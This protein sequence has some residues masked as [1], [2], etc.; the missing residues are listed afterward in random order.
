MGRRH[1][2]W[3]QPAPADFRQ[4]CDSVDRAA[5]RRIEALREL[6]ACELN[7]AQFSRL[8]RSFENARADG[9]ASS[10]ENFTLGLVSN[11][12]TDL[13]TPV[14]RGTGLRYGFALRVAN[15]PFGITWQAATSPEYGVL[16][17]DPDA[18]LLALDFRAYFK[19]YSLPDADAHGAVESAIAQLQ[20][21]IDAFQ[22]ACRAA[23]LVQSIPAPPEGLF[24]SLDRCQ[25][26]TP[27]WLA[28][29]FN[30]QL[31]AKVMRPG[32]SLVDVE[33]L[34]AQVGLAT[35][36]DRS[37]Y[38]TARL[39]FAAELIPLYADHVLRV[40]GAIRGRGRKVLVLDLDNTLWGGV[41]GDDG[42]EGI[43]LG[44][45]D[46]LG[47]ASQDLQ[48]AALALKERGV[49]LAVCSKN[50]EAVALN[51]IQSHVEMILRE[52]DFS[53]FQIN[54]ADKATNLEILAER[55][56][57]GLD[58]FVFLD[59]NPFEREQ[60][61]RSLPEVLVPELPSDPAT[62]ARVLMTGGFFE[63]ITFAAEDRERVSQYAAN[64]RRET[65]AA[66]S[67]DLG[68]FLR[69]LQMEA[70]FTTG[71]DLGWTRLA[72][73][74][75]K[76]NQFNLTTRRYTEAEVMAMVADSDTLTMQVRLVDRFGDNGMISAI[77]CKP[78]GK[79]WV[80]DT[81]VM[82]CRVLGRAVEQAVLNRLAE[83]ARTRGIPR[84]IGTYR[85][86]ERNGMVAEH[87]FKLGFTRGAVGD[88][89]QWIL[90]LAE[91]VAREVPIA[92]K[93]DSTEFKGATSANSAA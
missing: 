5:G 48:R 35:W 12:T 46:P 56:S 29:R 20:N 54:W 40:I 49:L 39:P 57:L 15:A 32:V 38:L 60:V 65:L 9:E 45:G 66:Q 1:M 4:R 77:I 22:S 61:R 43:R 34:A 87:Y 11:A 64:R 55:L 25:P 68:E 18:I 3:L 63:T 51:A 10:L 33:A 7:D 79:D 75:N 82:S 36:H 2:Q 52:D 85:P 71:G 44:Q 50:D 67:R 80:I 74:I 88:E 27:R 90:D 24:G 93:L 8:I 14:L 13:F 28:T 47:E 73:L 70:T 53:A 16:S 91:Y 6:A 84:L 62:Y 17:A 81:W 58:S 72:Q 78:S 21:L 37:Q 92:V 59:D 30:D 41:I 86:T 23:I 89:G 69:S 19:E 83:E 31:V 26:G 76:S 42:I